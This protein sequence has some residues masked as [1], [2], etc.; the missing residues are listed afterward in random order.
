MVVRH[1]AADEGGLSAHQHVDQV[2]ELILEV[3]ADSLEV[4]HLGGSLGLHHHPLLAPPV[5]GGRQVLLL[6]GLAR[7]V[8]VDLAH[9]G[10]GLGLLEQVDH[11]VVDG[12]SVLVEPSGHI[13]GDSSGIV[14]HSK[15]SVLV[16]GKNVLDGT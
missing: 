11:G 15:V 3:G 9:E 8:G 12:V 16:W 13:V 5:A 2:V 6:L 10:A 1:N 4:G 14:D 7:V